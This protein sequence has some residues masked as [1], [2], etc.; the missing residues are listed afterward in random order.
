MW[1][2]L[3]AAVASATVPADVDLDDLDGWEASA[4]AILDG[5]A[6]CWEIVG[7]A[8]WDW[9]VGR[10]GA[11][12]GDAVFAGR[13]EDGVWSAFHIESLGEVVRDRGKE[14]EEVH[15]YGDEPRFAPLVGNLNGSRVRVSSSDEAHPEEEASAAE[16]SAPGNLLRNVLDDLGGEVDTS[17]TQWDDTASGVVLH[18]SMATGSGANA[19]EARVEVFFPGG[20]AL[21]VSLDV[22]FPERFYRGTFPRWR[23]EDA[24]VHVR[25]RASHG[26]VFP[27]SESFRFDFGVLGFQ[28]HGAQTIVYK[29]ATRCK[30]AP[31][32]RG[33]A[34]IGEDPARASLT[35]ADPAADGA[36]GR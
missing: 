7:Q 21:P 4:E 5:P 2:F 12:R 26:T 14:A 10:F 35:R 25:G 1:L 28:F 27:T 3:A 11:S 16:S 18:R 23:V 22:T 24:V 29:N 32:A 13:L 6:G 36:V 15:Q 34:S 30:V 31:A 9:D 20:E 33:T 17:W 19:P 8:T